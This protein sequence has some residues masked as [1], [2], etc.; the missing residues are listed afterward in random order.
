MEK[1]P[2]VTIV[3]ATHNGERYLKEAIESVI[4]QDYPN[5]EYLIIN[6]AST[7]KTAEILENY[8]KKY[9]WIRIITNDK[10]LERSLSRN[11][12]IQQAGGDFIAFLDDDDFFKSRSKLSKQV[13][14]LMNNQDYVLVGT[15]IEVL[16]QN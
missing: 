3:T 6:D 10:N 13:D 15:N 1:K 14:F 8:E 11:L 12:G 7:D 2:L 4:V 9:P 5:K 16:D